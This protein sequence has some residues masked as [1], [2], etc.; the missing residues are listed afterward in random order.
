MSNYFYI[1]SQSAGDVWNDAACWANTSG[2]VGGAGI[3]QPMKGVVFDSASSRNCTIPVGANASCQAFSSIGYTGTL[4]LNDSFTA[5]SVSVDSNANWVMNAYFKSTGNIN[6]DADATITGLMKTFF[7]IPETPNSCAISAPNRIWGEILV[8]TGTSNGMTQLS[9]D[10]SVSSLDFQ[11]GAFASS[12]SDVNVYGGISTIAACGGIDFTDSV[13][14]LY[15]G[16]YIE[17]EFDK[18]THLPRVYSV[19]SGTTGGPVDSAVLGFNL[20]DFKGILDFELW[21]QANI[22]EG[23]KIT[24]ISYAEAMHKQVVVWETGG[25]GGGG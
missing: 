20:K 2:G 10:L 13:V 4:T 22:P 8:G 16:A 14:R 6:I 5:A 23:A 7:A 18:I 15:N 17:N 11:S 24:N 1:G 12:G 9:A 3:P 21:L 25:G 19:S